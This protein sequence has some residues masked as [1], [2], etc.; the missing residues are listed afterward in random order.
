VK[1]PRPGNSSA[2]N[3]RAGETVKRT[4][5]QGTVVHEAKETIQMHV[6]STSPFYPKLLPTLK[7]VEFVSIVEFVTGNVLLTTILIQI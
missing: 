1:K 3:K 2:R 4:I 5:V 7:I 6:D